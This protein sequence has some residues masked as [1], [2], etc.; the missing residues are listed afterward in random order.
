LDNDGKREH[1][2]FTALE[3]EG[4]GERLG[5]AG[6]PVELR[7]AAVRG[8]RLDIA[9]GLGGIG[10]FSVLLSPSA[11][12]A[13][14]FLSTGRFDVSVSGAGHEAEVLEFVRVLAFRHLS[15]VE[16]GDLLPERFGLEGVVGD[17]SGVGAGQGA[18]SAGSDSV[19]GKLE[20]AE[21]S[22]T[23]GCNLRCR[24]CAPESGCALA[25]ELTSSEGE[26][27]L[28]QLSEM[29]VL[30]VG[31]TGGE[32]LERGDGVELVGVAL[33]LFPS[34]YLSTNGWDTG[35]L[36][37]A[38]PTFPN[39]G[40]LE[41]VVSLDGPREAHDGRRGLGSFD[42]ALGFVGSVPG[43]KVDILTT[44]GSDTVGGLPELGEVL[45][46]LGVNWHIQP[47]AALGR[48]SLHSFRG[49]GVMEA[50]RA[51]LAAVE[52]LRAGGAFRGSIE[53]SDK[54]SFLGEFPGVGSWAGCSCG[55]STVYIGAEGDVQACSGSGTV[56]GNVKREPLLEIWNRH[57]SQRGV[58]K[59]FF[60]DAIR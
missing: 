34:V 57:A 24:H 52:A 43:Y 10:E 29:G 13:K 8:Q 9:F 32:F 2:F 36:L 22:G 17:G 56:W 39:R 7:S 20:Y 47:M 60:R 4:L 37:E 28:R 21:W 38:L 5:L 55:R 26:S 25:D 35:R 48:A 58:E 53:V 19:V 30:R 50:L 11:E 40:G 59:C 49:K 1:S 3:L 54:F 15:G 14:R 33:G 27:L 23:N 12:G 51:D 44:V 45:S 6:L 41:F 46:E 31:L 16:F 18:A 42:R